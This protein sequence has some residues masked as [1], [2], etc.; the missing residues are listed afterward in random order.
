MCIIGS[1]WKQL[2]FQR[3]QGFWLREVFEFAYS[4]PGCPNR[5]LLASLFHVL[6]GNPATKPTENNSN[7][8]EPGGWEPPKGWCRLWRVA[9]MCP[10]GFRKV[11]P[12]VLGVS[13]SWVE[14]GLGDRRA[15]AEVGLV[16]SLKQR[17]SLGG[18]GGIKVGTSQ[19]PRVLAGLG[20][21]CSLTPQ[22]W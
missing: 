5:S 2:E 16:A 22:L 7:P 13:L 14:V 19:N 12:R 18:P 3:L 6:T 11:R 9:S 15:L 8:K 21:L 10:V 20:V 17:I 4:L 1:Q